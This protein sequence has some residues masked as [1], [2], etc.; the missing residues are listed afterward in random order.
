MRIGRMMGAGGPETLD[1]LVAQAKASEAA[2]FSSVWLANIFS[3]DAIG[4]LAVVGRETERIELGTAVVPTYPRHPVTMAQQ[5][6]TTQAASGGRFSLGLGLSHQIVIET[7]LGLSYSRRASHM[8]EYLEVL[9]P[10]L[11]GE[12]AAFSGEEYRV[13]ASLQ[14]P[15]ADPVPVLIAAL[16]PAMLKLAGTR[17]AGTITWMTGPKTLEAHTVPGITAA[18]SEAGRPA[19]R[20][21]AGLPIA[22]TSDTG[23]ARELAAKAFEVYGGLP[24]YRAMLDREGAAGPA[25]V[26]V[27]GDEAALEAQLRRLEEIGVTD[28]LAAPFPADEGAV[29]RTLA[30]LAGRASR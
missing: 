24:S 30:F 29:E 12:P 3:F 27:V 25:D 5:A 19:P 11:R 15:G 14:V 9:G 26:A 17:T 20:V 6:L 4:A 1:D 2:G 10:L 13:Q 23:A 28:F 7:L 21:V 16:G 8:R 18:A 22:L